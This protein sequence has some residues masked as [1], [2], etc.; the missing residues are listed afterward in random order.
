MTTYLFN[1]RSVDSEV[2]NWQEILENAYAAKVRP[3]CGCR[4]PGV[5]M[6]ISKIAGI[7]HIKRMPETG[8][9]HHVAC[10]SYDPPPELSGLGEVMGSAIKEDV[11]SGMTSLRFDFALTKTSGRTAPTPSDTEHDSVKT[12]STKLTIRALLH[13]LWDRSKLTHWQPAWQGKRS[14]GTIYKQL[15]HAAHGN[16]AKGLSLADSLYVPQPFFL[17][18]KDEI[19][20]QRAAFLH[21]L[22]QTDG[23]ARR[24]GIVVAEVKAIENAR[25]GFNIVFKQ[26]PDFHF[27]LSEDAHKRIH[28]RFENELAL[29]S[30]L[31][32]SHL[33]AIATF[34]V[35]PTGLASIEEI[36][37]MLTSENWIPFTD[38]NEK[39]LIDR[40]T[41]S[42][43]RFI[44][45]LR[46]NMSTKR[47]LASV[48]L[49]DTFPAPTAK[50][51]TPADTD[52]AY[53]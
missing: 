48:E 31:D 15:S 37:L 26:V 4:A 8:S 24:L 25:Y 22:T 3:V 14:W 2:E 43:R 33:L 11:D 29:W 46:Y 39:N 28:K 35:G 17:D 21:S 47:P 34:G 49:V 51:I 32:G 53:K 9:D 36:A 7:F 16:Q 27:M 42:S 19:A 30:A 13:Y 45:G 5:P 38:L 40:L 23:K 18:R 1:H 44:K 10:I 52:D 12:D 6:Y 50:F 20:G 41:E